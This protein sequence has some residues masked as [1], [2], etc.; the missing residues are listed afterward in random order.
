[1]K[2][3]WKI[4]LAILSLTLCLCLL[5]C[6]G[7][8][9]GTEDVFYASAGDAVPPSELTLPTVFADGMVFQRQKRTRH[10]TSRTILRPCSILITL[11]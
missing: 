1:M 10:W 4:L 8:D 9:D 7:E 11:A 6:G 5:S 2:K 3:Y